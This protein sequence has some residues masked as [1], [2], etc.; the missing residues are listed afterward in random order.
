MVSPID[1]AVPV[2]VTDTVVVTDL[3]CW[4]DTDVGETL[5][6]NDDA[7]TPTVTV[8]QWVVVVSPYRTPGGNRDSNRSPPDP[9]QGFVVPGDVLVPSRADQGLAGEVRVEELDAGE[10]AD[11]EAEHSRCVRTGG[12]HRS[13]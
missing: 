5:T 7:L 9:P 1:R 3:P 8:A 4:A 12:K 10:G 11:H 6:P 13:P 2:D